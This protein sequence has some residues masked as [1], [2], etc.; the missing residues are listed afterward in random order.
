MRKYHSF[1]RKASK[2]QTRV[3]KLIASRVAWLRA[4]QLMGRAKLA[5]VADLNHSVVCDLEAQR[6]G[7]KNPTIQTLAKIA[8]ALDC[9]LAV[10]MWKRSCD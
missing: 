4:H 3:T 2:Q 9:N 6:K 8:E 5:L 10:Y 7:G 1:N